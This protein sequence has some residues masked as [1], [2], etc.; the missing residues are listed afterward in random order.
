MNNATE[1]Q[2][3]MGVNVTVD[4]ITQHSRLLKKFNADTQRLTELSVISNLKEIPEGSVTVRYEAAPLDQIVGQYCPN[5][6]GHSPLTLFFNSD[7]QFDHYEK[8][9]TATAGASAA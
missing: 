2:V 4:Q 1:N 6:D 8:T 7:G 9:S 3:P 5:W